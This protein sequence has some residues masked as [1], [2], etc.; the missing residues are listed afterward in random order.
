M[1][2]PGKGN[3]S[4]DA[5][6]EIVRKISNDIARKMASVRALWLAVQNEP[7]RSVQDMAAEF[8]FAVGKL[9]EGMQ[10]EEIELHTIDPKRVFPHIKEG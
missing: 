8:Y 6:Q 3:S 9:L 10:L 5:A 7:D 1:A 4:T 2:R